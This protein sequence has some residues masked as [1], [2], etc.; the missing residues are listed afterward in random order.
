V[1]LG[2]PSTEAAGADPADRLHQHRNL[3]KA[4][5]ENPATQ[6]EAVAE[7]E[8]ALAL[9]P[10]SAPERVNLGLALL[11]AG[12]TDEG[13]AQLV[14]AQEQDPT[15][16]HTW[17]NLG[18]AY[19]RASDYPK[20]IAQ[21]EG[22]AE[23]VPDE[24]IT[25][26][27]L[28]VLHKLQGDPEA[29][30]RH[31]ER[32]AELD[33]GLAGPHFQLA[34]AYR[35]AGR[36]E[37][38]AREMARFREL[39][40][41]DAGA[42]V[43]EDLEWSWYAEI[44]ETIEPEPRPGVEAEPAFEVTELAGGLDPES[45]GLLVLRADGSPVPALLAWSAQGLRLLH[46]DAE[47]AGPA[48][49]N[50]APDSTAAPADP[51][52]PSPAEPGLGGLRGVR[53]AA[54]GDF[55]NDGRHDLAVLTGRALLLANRDDRFEPVEAL[56]EAAKRSF[57]LALWLDYDHDYDLDLL[58]LG[59]EP[60]LLRNDG[61]GPDGVTWS[62]RTD[63]FPFAALAGGGRITAAARFDLVADTQGI[64]LA[65]AREGA[66]AV[67]FRDLLGGRYE[68][69]ELPELPTGTR[70]LV[71]ADAD[72]DGWTD[73][74]ASGVGGVTVLRNRHRDA[75][76]LGFEAVAVAPGAAAG[77][78]DAQGTAPGGT[79]ASERTG[80]SVDA[81]APAGPVVVFDLA[82]RGAGDLVVG[83]RIFRDLGDARF[84]DS[85]PF[86]G[87]PE[88]AP[89]VTVLA[90][91][92]L[93][94]D[95]RTDL[96]GID[97]RGSLVKMLNRT[98]TTNGHLRI[99]LTGIKNPILAPGAE[100]EV[101]AGSLYQKRLYDGVPLVFGLGGRKQ[102][103][104]VRITWPNGLIQNET[105]QPAGTRAAYEE[106]QR[107]SGSC[108]MIF[109][110]NG[111]EYEFITDVLGV[112]PLGASA[113]DG[114]YFPVDHDEVIQVPGEALA[115]TPEGR[116]EVRITEELREVAFLDQIRLLAV[117]HPEGLDVFTNDKFK[118]PPFPDFRLFGVA[119]AERRYPVAARDHHGRDVRD[120]LLARDETYPDGFR[121]DYSGL[122]ELHHLELDF[123]EAADRP[124]PGTSRPGERTGIAGQSASGP[125]RTP[126]G[127]AAPASRT[128]LVLSG[129]VDWADG[130][131]F[132]AT[133]QGEG[134]GLVLPYLQVK[135]DAG[136]WVTVIEDMG[137]PAGKPKT[138]VVDLTGK[139][140]S[141]SRE[142][143]IV[144][145]ACVYWDEIFL[146][147]DALDCRPE[148]SASSAV[149]SCRPE[150]SEAES[151]DLGGGEPPLR[152]A[153]A[154]ALPV[155]PDAPS[156]P[157]DAPSCRPERSEAEPRDLGGG[158]PPLRL[159]EVPVAE[160]HLR[161]RGF[162]RPVIHPE[163]KQPERF[164]YADRRPTTMWNPTPGRYTRYGDIA[165]LLA[166]VDDRFV[167]MGSGDEVSL[168]FEARALP[169]LPAGW[170]RD[171][172]LVVDGW[173]KDGDA[174]TAHSQ[175]VGPLPY[176]GMP[177]YPYDQPHAY[178]DT[179]EHRLYQEH[180]LTR[181]A[182]RLIRP[183][184]EG[185][186]ADPRADR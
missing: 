171:F 111:S 18:L 40:A 166:T 163:R 116:Y 162:S 87:L 48:T 36:A 55:D 114:E 101:K 7:F 25:H 113:G 104:A 89:A 44:Y 115:A 125:D 122:A 132:L 186:P 136:E 168:S 133:A 184:T 135:D 92:D 177:Q 74:V 149:S 53:H 73:L 61:P 38:A 105:R 84:A 98:E 144:T 185:T 174:N 27:N 160:T 93:D 65:V 52:P 96:V 77:A 69:A 31:F 155:P 178:P 11:R 21:L 176:H 106:A 156:C 4:L 10:D 154:L 57:D 94:G 14:K 19:K 15:I 6:Y 120:R 24:P 72:H 183:L 169:P 90:A 5:Y 39:K 64:D 17:F 91:A 85:Q 12:R 137:I 145:S 108:P 118:G 29:S 80:A 35:Q 3:G 83:D 182:L 158:V 37:D 112:A 141:D 161:F 76:H 51:G 34:S 130:S 43:P 81:G 88:G 60:A 103:D 82:N 121:R 42:A 126:E 107:L 124:G 95:G 2:P 26:Y 59:A 45:A 33:P 58:L 30:L 9:A 1:G 139:W 173:A 49:Q 54:A 129:W 13:I 32:A 172:L 131:T 146:A 86:L 123:G 97:A 56:P 167:V 140:L 78:P 100:V 66:P 138:I 128:I 153:Q 110:W 147:E 181:P 134:P 175:T 50:P 159:A 150:R 75:R 79:R 117:D 170:R 70:H 180:Y 164:V 71:A 46:L 152:T 143:R 62:D 20:A 151:R 157:P 119:E 179:P 148:D 23:R 8:A 142:V 165:E 109:T 127:E 67:L 102:A 16:P 68:A 47:A 28:G 22:M 63:A 99:A 41:R